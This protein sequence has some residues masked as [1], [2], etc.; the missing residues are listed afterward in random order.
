[1][2]F[3]LNIM[4]NIRYF[5]TKISHF[6]YIFKIICTTVGYCAVGGHLQV[7]VS[8]SSSSPLSSVG[9]CSCQCCHRR[10]WVPAGVWWPSSLVVEVVVVV[11]VVV[12]V[13]T[14]VDRGGW[15]EVVVV[16]GGGESQMLK[17]QIRN[18]NIV[19]SSVT[20][21]TMN[22][23]LEIFQKSFHQVFSHLNRCKNHRFMFIFFTVQNYLLW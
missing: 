4:E 3:T 10:L 12:M 2:F 14:V 15:W 16:G 20:W 7:L 5:N 6:N 18:F 23:D 8:S 9:T 1:M 22:L 19:M 17:F 11:V 21:L 13:V